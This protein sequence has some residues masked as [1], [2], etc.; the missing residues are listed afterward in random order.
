MP[1]HQS[2]GVQRGLRRSDV[3]KWIAHSIAACHRRILLFLRLFHMC[4][5][6]LGVGRFLSLPAGESEGLVNQ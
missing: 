6:P 5:V 1:L 2:D 3:S 4:H